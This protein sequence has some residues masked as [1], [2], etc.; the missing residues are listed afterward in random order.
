MVVWVLG[1]GQGLIMWLGRPGTKYDPPASAS[2]VLRLYNTKLFRYDKYLDLRLSVKLKSKMSLL[3]CNS[4]RASI[5]CGTRVSQL[6]TRG[7]Y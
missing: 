5:T 6:S 4:L 2:G 1:A 7:N 3:L